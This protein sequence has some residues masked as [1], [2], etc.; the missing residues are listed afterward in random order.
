MLK[1]KIPV[2]KAVSLNVRYEQFGTFLLTEKFFSK[3]KDIS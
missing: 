1:T 3:K 2:D